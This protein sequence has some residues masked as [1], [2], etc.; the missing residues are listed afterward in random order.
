MPKSRLEFWSAKF[1]DNI[2]RDQ[3]A[4][5]A[6][7]AQGWTAIVVCET[8]LESFLSRLVQQ[9]L[10]SKKTPCKSHRSTKAEPKWKVAA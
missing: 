9:I 2:G 7:Q 4:L 5:E 8:Q 6:L 3:R 1:A 10:E